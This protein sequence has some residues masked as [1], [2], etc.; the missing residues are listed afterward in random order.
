MMHGGGVV[1]LLVLRAPLQLI[2][3]PFLPIKTFRARRGALTSEFIE[4]D[5]VL[6]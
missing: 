3:I 1:V 5:F 6:M 2:I 4:S